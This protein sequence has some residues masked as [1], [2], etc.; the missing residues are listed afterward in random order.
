[1][2]L[3]ADDIKHLFHGKLKHVSK[4]S[5]VGITNT[6]ID[7]LVFIVSNEL[8]GVNYILSQVLGYSF[9]VINS[10]ILNKKWTFD[11]QRSSKKTVHELVQ[12]T[13]VNLVSLIIT[14]VAMKLLVTNLNLNLY[15]S[16][17]LVTC[18]AQV[19]NFCG[20]KLWVFS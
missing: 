5:L 13:V 6:L 9:G 7:F 15:I 4:F 3:E 8:L 12:F 10:F 1:M 20:Y 17:V 19:T 18:I 16:K 14:M 11:D 2:K